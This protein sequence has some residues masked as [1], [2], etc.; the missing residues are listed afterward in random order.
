MVTCFICVA[1]GTQ[2]A[3]STE[4]PLECAICT[5]DRQYVP[6]EGQRWTTHDE[7]VTSQRLR[8]ELDDGLVGIGVHGRFGIPQRALLV[9][10]AVG[11]VMWDCIS[12]ATPAAVTE[13]QR[14]GG[15]EMIAI[16]HPHFYSSM[17]EWSDALGGVPILL[18]ADD[19]D[20]VMRPSPHIRFWHGDRLD[21]A[22][23]TT[24]LHLPGHFP[25]SSGLLH[26]DASS[27]RTRLLVGDSLHVAADRRHVTVMHSVP[28]YLP[29][30]PATILDLR[31]RLE[32]LHFDDL[33]G[34][35]WGLNIIGD[36]GA[37]VAQSLDR[38]L[39]AITDRAPRAC[40]VV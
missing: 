29:V 20:W 38:Y 22:D 4:P 7:L 37:A 14:R 17:V 34:F 26:Q 39:A 12:V 36:A 15:V 3:P 27:G 18:H 28:N 35:T 40:S 10:T 9:D 19:A 25:G 11:T 1:C 8:T 30:G 33:Y 32:G 16:S 23:D 13:L 5:D 21:I 31:R 24:L 2:Y 6:N